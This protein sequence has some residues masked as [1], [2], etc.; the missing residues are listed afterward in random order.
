MLVL[1]NDEIFLLCSSRFYLFSHFPFHLM[2]CAWKHLITF[3]IIARE[4]PP[5]TASLEKTIAKEIVSH[6]VN[7]ENDVSKKLNTIIESQITTVQKQKRVVAKCHQ[8]NEAAK[9]KYQ[10]SF[11]FQLTCRWSSNDFARVLI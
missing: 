1:S 2:R 9:Q 8:D 4:T 3:I 10:V 6:E 5:L 11:R 7:I